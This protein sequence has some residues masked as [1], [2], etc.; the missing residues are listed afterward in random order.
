MGPLA[1]TQ[2]LAL[3]S[4]IVAMDNGLVRTPP[5]GWMAWERFRCDIDCKDDPKNCIRYNH[6]GHFSDFDYSGY[7]EQSY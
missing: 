3:I 7:S 2:L 4:L 5:M 1:V 6:F